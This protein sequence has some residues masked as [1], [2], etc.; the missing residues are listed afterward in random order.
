[1]IVNCDL[2]C[3][4]SHAGGAGSLDLLEID[5]TMPLKGISLVG[6][7][8]CQYPPWNEYLKQ[9]LKEIANSGIYELKKGSKTKFVLQTELVFTT[10][11][12]KRSKIAHVVF[13]FRDFNIVDDFILLLEE[14]WNIKIRGAKMGRPFVT[15][16]NPEEIGNKINAILDLHPETECFPAHILTPSGVFGSNVRINCLEDFFAGCTDRI[17]CVETGLSADP[18]ILS[19]IPELEKRTW[20]SNSDA[21]SAALNRIGREFTTFDIGNELN[22]ENLIKAIRQNQVVRTA[23]FLPS[24]G[25]YFLTGH[26][27][28]KWQPRDEETRK[29]RKMKNWHGKNEFC[30][31]SP[32]HVPKDDKCPICSREL[33]IG[34]LQ[35]AFEISHAQNGKRGL[36]DLKPNI[37]DYIHMVPLVEVIG[38]AYGI[39]SPTAKKVV[40]TYEKILYQLNTTEC[41]FWFIDN[42]R[43][44]EKLKDEKRLI[45]TLIDVK[46]GNFCFE[47]LGY[48]G[49]YG[50]LC[51]GKKHQLQDLL[52]ISYELF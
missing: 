14:K 21:H 28:L 52:T 13:L 32:N 35:R 25:R 3:H 27:E 15:C 17:A 45:N 23:E 2:H 43:I 22:Y 29:K 7:G 16:Q 41:D 5:Q 24:E 12:Q 20:I 33:A 26:R 44:R 38:Y 37:P 40:S 50:K 34:V 19:L 36:G 42:S 4:S 39:K 46:N 31:Y 6:T 9:T 30:F 47:P 8:D 49:T 1:M 51:V 11:I 18:V 48:D 10:K